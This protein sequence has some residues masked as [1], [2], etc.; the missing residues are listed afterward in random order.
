M[1]QRYQSSEPKIDATAYVHPSAVVIGEVTLGPGVSV[2]PTAVLRGDNG[3]LSLGQDTNFQDGAIAHAT[4]G[5]SKTELGQ[6]CTVGHRAV[7]H[8]CKIGN[9]CLIGIGATILDG[10]ELGDFCFVGAGA[11]ITPRRKFPPRSFILGAPA[12]VAR[13]VT[14]KDLEWIDHS[15]RVYAELCRTYRAG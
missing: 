6:R 1:L 14:A 8:G 3:P 9:D 11:L 13:E 4:L 7:L 15:W 12:T 10:A 2:W 5:V